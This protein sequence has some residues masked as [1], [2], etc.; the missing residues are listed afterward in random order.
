ERGGYAPTGAFATT[1]WAPTA[2][3]NSLSD[4]VAVKRVW[5]EY[6]TP[7]GLLRFGRMA[8]HWGLGM[9]VN[10]GNGH[11]SDYGSTADRLLFVTG[12]KSWDLYFG[13]LWDF[14]NEGPT[15]ATLTERQGQPYDL[16]QGDDV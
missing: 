7:I 16:A 1:Q 14:A 3:Q 8:S 13:A 12:I 6:T 15:S 10:D 5:G 11:D 4:S 2:G 9:L